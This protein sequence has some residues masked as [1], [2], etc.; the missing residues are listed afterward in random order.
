MLILYLY[1][2]LQQLCVPSIS[3]NYTFDFSL[4]NNDVAAPRSSFECIRQ[5]TS[6]YVIKIIHQ[7]INNK[8][9]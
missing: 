8:H 7:L 2:L 6:R 1:L 3:K 5:N 9:L 4:S